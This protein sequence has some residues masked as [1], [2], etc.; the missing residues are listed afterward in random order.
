MNSAREQQ[1]IF[2]KTM[3]DEL[4]K[5]RR[6]VDALRAAKA[7][8]AGQPLEAVADSLVTEILSPSAKSLWSIMEKHPETFSKSLIVMVRAGE[9][10]GVLDKIAGRIV[11]ELEGGAMPIPRETQDGKTENA[12]YW[13]MFGQMLRSGVPIIEALEDVRNEIAGEKL[14]E[15]TDAL[16]DAV[17]NRRSMAEEMARWPDL[18]PPPA[19]DAVARGEKEGRLDEMASYVATAFEKGQ[20]VPLEAAASPPSLDAADARQ[21]VYAVILAA[22]QANASDVH[23]DSTEDG[24]GRVRLRIDGALRDIQPPCRCA[25]ADV[26]SRFKVMF[27]G[28][29]NEHRIVQDGRIAM[30]ISGR[31]IDIRA[32]IVPAALGE[33]VVMRFFQREAVRLM[34]EDIGLAGDDLDKVRKLCGLGHGL[35]M[36]CGPAG[37]GKTTLMYAMIKSIARP[38]VNVMSIEEPIEYHLPDVAQ[39][40]IN[41][42]AGLTLGRVARAV[43]RQDPDVIMIGE[44][45]DV[46]TVQT[47]V[48]MALTGHLVITQTHA[49]TAPGCVR[50]LIDVGVEAY[51]VGSSLGGV[52]A[53][54]LVRVLCEKC[55]QKAK[56]TADL[57]PRPIAAQPEVG[58][59]F[60]SEHELA[61]WTPKGCD[62]CGATGYRGRTDIHEILIPT[63]R[64][65]QVIA[66]APDV[67]DLRKVAIEEGMNPMIV[68]ALE[69]VVQGKT[70]LT[71]ALTCSAR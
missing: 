51:L 10:G 5:G 20:F 31:A 24:C 44:M 16:I 67:V 7:A 19:C 60:K 68:S 63:E 47:A 53:Q 50:R 54:R 37:S 6:L 42:R 64:L 70:S 12:R 57:L 22:V 18:F 27:D 23:L 49:D 39:I 33:R 34:L 71:E 59:F 25:F 3:R 43:M 21:Y 1:I 14:R 66:T 32:N 17:T 48:Q 15:A 29:V 8:V 2:W 62:Q 35:V 28:D 56:L 38:E 46:E 30:N 55:K 61:M 36:G 52:I 65:R 69:K 26:V 40:E 4:V 41:P 9:A 58:A 45:R 13:R 11:S